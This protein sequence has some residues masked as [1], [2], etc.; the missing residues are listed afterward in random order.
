MKT[1]DF[2]K[3][4]SSKGAKELETTLAEKTSALRNFR[5]AVAGSNTR[6]VKEGRALKREIARLKTV[7][8]A[9]K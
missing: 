5:F 9:K 7:M 4:I 2:K 6:N 8:N 3:N 1:K